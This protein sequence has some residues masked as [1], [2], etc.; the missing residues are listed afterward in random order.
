ML[1]PDLKMVE[2]W[3]IKKAKYIHFKCTRGFEQGRYIFN[4]CTH[5]HKPGKKPIFRMPFSG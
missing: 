4:V 3:K 2:K 5:T 1:F